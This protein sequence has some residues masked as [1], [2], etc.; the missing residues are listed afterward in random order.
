[1]RRLIICLSLAFV[2]LTGLVAMMG[3]STRAQESTPAAMADHPVVGG[4]HW[5]NDLGDGATLSTYA[6]F[7]PDGTYVESFGED[8]TDVGVW[9]PTG[10]RTAD[11]TLYSAD[12]DPDPDVTVPVVSRLA[13]EVDETGN[14]ITAEGTYQGLGEDGAVLF[15]GPGIARGTRLEVLSVIPPGTPTAA[16]PAP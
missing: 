2:V 13:I 1:M 8:G 10:A 5:E 16:T 6:A 3:R 12:G 15:S 4:W 11:L 7:H 9:K 14:A